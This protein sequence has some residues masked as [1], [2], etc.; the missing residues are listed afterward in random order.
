MSESG[1]FN[2]RAAYN[3][4]DGLDFLFVASAFRKD[5]NVRGFALFLALLD[6]FRDSLN[7]V[8]NFGNE[9]IFRAAADTRIQ[10]D[11]AATSAHNFNERNAIV[12]SHGV[13][14]IVDRPKHGVHGCVETEGVV[15]ISEIVVDRAGNA[16]DV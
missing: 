12:R 15:G 3:R 4:N 14:K 11:V 7:V 6:V 1:N 5:D 16:D 13:A 2:V 9:N 8:R 10:S